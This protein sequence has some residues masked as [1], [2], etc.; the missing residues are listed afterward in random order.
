MEISVS[1]ARLYRN[2]QTFFC[3]SQHDEIS[4][5]DGGSFLCS[6]VQLAFPNSLLAALQLA[7]GG[8]PA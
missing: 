3:T 2:L 4:D 5:V 8:R 7:P 1:V 6:S